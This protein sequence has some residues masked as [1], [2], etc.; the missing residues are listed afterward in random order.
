MPLLPSSQN[1]GAQQW[2]SLLRCNQTPRGGQQGL[3][4]LLAT[5][6]SINTHQRKQ[7]SDFGMALCQNE[8]ETTKVIKEAKA[9][10][11][12][13][14]RDVKTCWAVLISEAKVRHTACIKEIKD[15]C[16]H[17]LAEAENCYS[18]AIRE[19]ESQGASHACSIQQ[20]HAKY[21]QHLEA[22][23]IE[24]E[25]RDCLA[26][27]ATCVTTL[28][29]SP[30]KACGIMVTPFHLLL[31]NAPTSTL[32]S[33]P[34]GVSP[35]TG[36]CPA[37]SSFLCP[38]RDQAFTSVQAVAPLTQPGGASILIWDYLLSDSQGAPHSKWKE[39]MLF[40]KALSRSHQVA[41][42]RDSRLL[43][44][45]REHSY[46]ENHLHFDSKTSCDMADIFWS[47]IK[48]AS[49]LHSKIYEIQET[50][51]GWHELQYANYA[52]KP[53]QKGWNSS[54]Q[55]PSQSPQRSWA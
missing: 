55:C 32:L 23:A 50:W 19:A 15:N 29:A 49:L 53:C 5:K 44:R 11:A 4:H 21:I 34:P 12:C 20:S 14:S 45:V 43:Q 37:D 9:L 10:S 35:S 18:T 47:M 30:P 51:T 46:W 24:E 31:G 25:R 1:S 42:S 16:A 26:F 33:I 13:T 52:L 28:R 40:H 3:G 8:S 27:L 17:A 48:S 7:V 38:S 41:F 22:E 2:S 54:A 39:E 36:T 6:P